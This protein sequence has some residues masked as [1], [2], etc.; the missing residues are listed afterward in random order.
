MSKVVIT[1]NASGTGDFTIAAPNSNTN[2]T[3]TLPD[4]AGTVLT[5]AGV[6]SSA[7][8]AGSVLQVV[9]T[10][11]GQTIVTTASSSYVSMGQSVSITPSSVSSKILLYVI[12]GGHYLPVGNTKASITIFRGATNIGDSDTGLE[13]VYTS[14]T[15]GFTFTA[16]SMMVLDSPATTSSVTYT[17]YA[18]TTGGTYQYQYSDRGDINFV[19]MEIAG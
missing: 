4:E 8:P 15:T 7:M 9:Q 2:R 12:G 17:T 5:T 10:T 11:M 1:G 6:P 16:H 19:A 14:G 18:K 3:L 13:S